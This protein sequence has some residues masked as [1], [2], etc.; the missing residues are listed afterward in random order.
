MK[1]RPI[2]KVESLENGILQVTFD[3]GNLVTVDMKPFF[4][5]FRFG[6][7]QHLEIWHSVDTNGVFV[8]WYKSG[9]PVPVAVLAH[10][11]IMKM[12]LGESY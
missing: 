11:E 7:L 1:G 5:G 9:C 3:T 8:H 12:T 4:T 6:A 10:D 2:T